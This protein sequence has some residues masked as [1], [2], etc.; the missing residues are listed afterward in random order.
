[1]FKVEDTWGLKQQFVI[2]QVHSVFGADSLEDSKALSHEVYTPDEIA[3][4]FGSISY[5]KGAS[6]IRMFEH[7]LGNTTFIAALRNY[8]KK[9]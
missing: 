3:E 5:N 4:R 7:A 8:L 6:V 1:M 9:K 2:E